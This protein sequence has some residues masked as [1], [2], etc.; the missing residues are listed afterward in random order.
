G[1]RTLTNSAHAAIWPRQKSPARRGIRGSSGRE[2]SAHASTQPIV[3]AAMNAYPRGGISFRC[4]G[5]S[6]A[7]MPALKVTA[8]VGSPGGLAGPLAP[9]GRV[10]HGRR[11]APGMRWGV[12]VV[13][14]SGGQ[15]GSL[16]ATRLVRLCGRLW[17]AAGLLAD[18]SERS[19]HER[20]DAAVVGVGAGREVRRRV[21]AQRARR[22]RAVLSHRHRFDAELSRVE[23]GC[24]GGGPARGGG[25]GAP[26]ARG[27]GG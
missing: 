21:P 2:T 12:R 4:S 18:N 23:L 5:A 27:P 17:A 9:S 22:G 20:V 10:T 7:W 13:L 25:G 1:T 14:M 3:A 8:S 15:A 24:G 26:A 6:A 11:W 16:V 19:A